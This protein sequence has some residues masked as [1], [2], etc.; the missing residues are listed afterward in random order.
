MSER[1]LRAEQALELLPVKRRTLYTYASRGWIQTRKQGRRKL[2]RRIDVEAL[3]ERADAHAGREARAAGTL[4]WGEP[5]LTTAIS[6]HDADGPYYRGISALDLI[7]HGLDRTASV[8]WQHPVRIPEVEAPPCRTLPELAQLLLSAPDGDFGV[9]H[10]ARLVGMLR[11]ASGLPRHPDVEAALVLCADHGLNASTFAA[12]VVASTGASLESCLV[13]GLMALSG[14]RHGT[15]SRAVFDG[16]SAPVDPDAPGFSHPFY[17]HGDPRG[18]ALLERCPAQGAL[19]TRIE[20]MRPHGQPNLDVGLLAVCQAHGLPV[21][22]APRIF[23]VGRAVG[24]VAHVWEQRAEGRL[25]RP[26]ARYA[27]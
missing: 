1:W 23:A 18:E 19:A 13:A 22:T 4:A 24:W 2:Y 14:P 27:W 5:V 16:L 11:G 9:E 26:R 21:E 25:I 15:A 6:A 17:P 12:R 8:L 3:R 10:A 7:G 20:A